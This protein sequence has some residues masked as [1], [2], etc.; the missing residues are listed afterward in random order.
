[1][2]RVCMMVFLLMLVAGVPVT[3]AADDVSYYWQRLDVEVEVEETGDL[4]ITEIQTYVFTASH[5]NKRLRRIPLAHVDS[6]TDVEVYENG[7][8]LRVKT[9][10]KADQYWIRWRHRPSPPETRTFV[11][12]YRAKGGMY[13]DSRSD[14]M[15]WPALSEGR[16][17]PIQRSKVTVRV[18]PSLAGQ[19]RRFNHYG[20]PTDAQQ[21]D[22]RTVTFVPQ[23]A[24]QP[25][26][27]LTV[28]LYVPHGV[29]NAPIPAWQRGEE[30]VYHLPG[31]LGYI[32]TVV[33]VIFGIV[34]I[35]VWLSSTTQKSHWEVER[36][37]HGTMTGGQHGD[38]RG[39]SLITDSPG[40]S[41]RRSGGARGF[42][43]S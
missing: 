14:Q 5:S 17:A 12:R 7:R 38:Y 3:P 43:R 27:A 4:L 42:G 16:D 2:K 25:D 22:A 26:E 37:E 32:D 6:V 11:V 10:R 13:I 29:L 20:V 15:V 8:K 31:L 24:L 40:G 33:F 30:V 21:I 1:M 19:I 18:P 39:V 36:A 35:G 41:G 28:K 34:M 23:G 9:S